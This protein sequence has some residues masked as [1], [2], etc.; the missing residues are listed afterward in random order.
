MADDRL[1]YSKNETG[2]FPEPDEV[3]EKIKTMT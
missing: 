3:V 1:V 2:K